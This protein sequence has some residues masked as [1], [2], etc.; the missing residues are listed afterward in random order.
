MLRFRARILEDAKFYY[1]LY[2]S[3]NIFN[4]KTIDKINL[5]QQMECP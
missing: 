2:T 5:S 3:R 4:Y 1:Y